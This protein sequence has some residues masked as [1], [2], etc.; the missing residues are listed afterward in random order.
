[1]VIGL[2]KPFKIQNQPQNNSR[3]QD[4]LSFSEILAKLKDEALTNELKNGVS[5]ITR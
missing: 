1:L 5:F 3:V 2:E 4:F